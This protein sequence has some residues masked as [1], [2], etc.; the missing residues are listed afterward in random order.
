VLTEHHPDLPVACMSA[1]VNQY[2]VERRLSVPLLSKP[3]TTDGLRGLIVP[4]IAQSR[5]LRAGA[6]EQ[7]ARAAATR[8]ENEALRARAE[9]SVARAV[10]LIAIARAVHSSRANRH[11]Q[12]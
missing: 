10:D 4:L 5:H 6:H 3:F 12:D 1:F 2:N 9:M 8:M 7:R 11:R